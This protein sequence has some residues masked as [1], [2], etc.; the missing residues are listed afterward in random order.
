MH[1]IKK[2]S[3]LLKVISTSK[4]KLRDSIIKGS[5]KEFIYCICEC[6]LNLMNGN[7]NIDKNT[8]YKLKPYKN[9]FKKLL[10]KSQLKDKKRIIIQKGGFLQYLIPAVITSIST[11]VTELIK[12]N[13]E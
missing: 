4:K 2:N 12:N 11:I 3:R 6:V 13:K 8:Y 7:L 1:K 5:D 9:T 10:K